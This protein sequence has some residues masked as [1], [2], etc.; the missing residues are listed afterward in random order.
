[1]SSSVSEDSLSGTTSPSVEKS[2]GGKA[3]VATSRFFRWIPNRKLSADLKYTSASLELTV[4]ESGNQQFFGC[5]NNVH[6]VDG[7]E[8]SSFTMSLSSDMMVSYW[9]QLEENE[10]WF[11]VHSSTTCADASCLCPS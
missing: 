3:P 5:F 1:M 10:E 9:L 4:I 2:E 7:L 8:I 6:R 11:E